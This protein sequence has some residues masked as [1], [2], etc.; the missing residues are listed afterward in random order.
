MARNKYDIDELLEADF[1]SKQFLRALHYVKKYA[2]SLSG[3]LLLSILSTV[4]GLISPLLIRDITDLYI[5]AQDTHGIVRVAVIYVG[6]LITTTAC[7]LFRN[8]LTNYAGQHIVRDMRRDLFVHLQKLPFTY[9]DSRPHGKILV[10]VTNY[11][12]AVSNFLTSGLVSFVID[13]F[14]IAIIAVFMFALDWR[15]TLVSLL[16]VP[17]IIL[18]VGILKPKQQRAKRIYNNKSSNFHAY[19]NESIIGIRITQIFSR[20]D[21]N[22]EIFHRLATENKDSWQKRTRLNLVVSAVIDNISIIFTCLLYIAASWLITGGNLQLGVLLAM[23]RYSSRFWNPIVNLGN[24]YS[25]LAEVGAY[26]ERIFETMNEPVDIQ[27]LP[28]A[29]KRLLTGEVRFDQ[30][31]FEYEKGHRVLDNVSF[32]AKP[33]ERIALVGPTGSGKTTVVNLISRFYDVTEGTVLIDGLD[34]RKHDLHSLRSQMGIMLQDTFL[35]SGS[36]RDN[37]RYGNLDATDEEIEQAAKAVCAHDFIMH[38]TQGYDTVISERGQSLSA[39]QRQL[40]SFARTL[41][42]KPK[43]LI[44]DE[45]TS[46]ID[47]QTEKL[48]QEGIK[49]L[50]HGRTSFI[51]AHRLSTIQDC[52]RIMYIENGRIMETGNHEKLLEQKG[53]YY[54][55]YTSQ[56]TETH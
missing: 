48:L 4:A 29:E 27:S 34:I 25:Q 20:E 56:A 10:R 45:A 7:N 52:D 55:L 22:Q 53:Y 6:I 33:G 46:T 47:T 31:C 42:C 43:I 15:L 14:S 19:L 35:F 32:T 2:I 8:F 1:N 12:G 21:F 3:A 30:V 23:T 51:I 41:L 40:L 54:R 37:I 18:T 17:F 9:Y 44:L 50:M 26:L 11:V 28:G 49:A 38:T 13:I 36:I 24:L 5:P 39:G 16:G